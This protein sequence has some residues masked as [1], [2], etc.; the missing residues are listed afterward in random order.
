MGEASGGSINNIEQGLCVVKK[1]WRAGKQ[2]MMLKMADGRK[3][4]IAKKRRWRAYRLS[5][6][7]TVRRR[8]HGGRRGESGGVTNCGR[9]V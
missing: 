4:R 6:R 9:V 2:G 5:R 7:G 3:K 1:T 8:R